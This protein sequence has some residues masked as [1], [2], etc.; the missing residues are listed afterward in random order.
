MFELKAG[1][2]AITATGGCD[3][4]DAA[5][6]KYQTSTVS[7]NRAAELAGVSAEAFRKELADRR[8]RT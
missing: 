3:N 1:L 7:Y 6:E 8:D 2:N 5:V 4:T